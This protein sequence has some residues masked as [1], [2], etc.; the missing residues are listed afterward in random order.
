[1][2]NK[3]KLEEID[4]S[5]LDT[6]T[7]TEINRVLLHLRKASGTQ[8]SLSDPAVLKKVS[9]AYKKLND[10][11]INS[12]Y[13]DYKETLKSCLKERIRFGEFRSSASFNI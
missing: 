8:Y 5:S 9:R 12:L 2:K 11:E 1:M 6:K 7:I 4:I 3:V 13:R 10:P